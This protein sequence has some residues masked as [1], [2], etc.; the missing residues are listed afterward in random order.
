LLGFLE[1]EPE[2][3]AKLK[4]ANTRGRKFEDLVKSAEQAAMLVLVY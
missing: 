1:S 3:S 2:V 4:E